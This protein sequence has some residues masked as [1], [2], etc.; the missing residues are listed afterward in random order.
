VI[1]KT[2]LKADEGFRLKPPMACQLAGFVREFWRRNPSTNQSME[3]ATLPPP[4]PL[5]G[6]ISSPADFQSGPVFFRKLFSSAA[7]DLGRV[8]AASVIFY[9][10]VGLFSSLPLS[11]YCEKAVEYFVILAGVTYL[12]FSRPPAPGAGGYFAYIKR[13]LAALLPMF[14][15]V[16]VL[17]Y[18]GGFVFASELGRHFRFVEF[19]ASASGISLYLHWKYMSTVMW[20]MPFIVQVYLLLPWIDWLARRWHPVTLMLVAFGSSALL[21][22]TIAHFIHPSLEAGLIYKNWSPLFRLPEVC[23]GIILGRA[24]LQPEGGK[25]T[26][27]AVGLYGLL[28]FAAVWLTPLYLPEAG[29]VVPLILF[30]AAGVLTWR[31]Q[32][33]P[34]HWLRRWGTASFPF[35]LIHAAPLATL[36]HRFHNHLVVWLAYYIVCWLGAV[37]MTLVWERFKSRFDGLFGAGCQ[38]KKSSVAGLTR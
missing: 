9:F 3:P 34:A 24:A 6:R 16:N 36:S 27:L 1:L 4:P 2:F 15:L 35:F 28:P 21:A 22:Q 23:L 13:R 30:G 14:L 33:L 38:P 29:F 18:A 10:H 17:L 12:L 31:W 26:L 5:S 11:F 8:L 37:G 25:A 32:R 20:F 7:L 19:L